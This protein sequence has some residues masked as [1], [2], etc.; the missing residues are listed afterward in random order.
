M[1]RAEIRWLRIGPTLKM[2]GRLVGKWAEQARCLVSPDVVP[3]GLIVDLN[4]VMG[5]DAAGE[6][7]LRWL[8]SIGAVFAASTARAIAICERLG[9]SRQQRIP[10]PRH[11]SKESRSPVMHSHVS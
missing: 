11:G 4:E 2:K 3:K 7:L 5:V 9:L 8:A 1:F 6:R 10:V